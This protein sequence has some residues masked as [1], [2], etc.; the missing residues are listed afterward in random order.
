MESIDTVRR[1]RK[2]LTI[3]DAHPYHQPLDH[4]VTGKDTHCGIF[5]RSF[6]RRCPLCRQER[7]NH[8]VKK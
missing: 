3:S 2:V 5:K 8:E 7:Y 4:W 6:D 1:G